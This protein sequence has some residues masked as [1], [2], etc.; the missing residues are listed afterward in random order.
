[1]SHP[2]TV[3]ADGGFSCR[4]DFAVKVAHM[5]SCAQAAYDDDSC[6]VTELLEEYLRGSKDEQ[7]CIEAFQKEW[8]EAFPGLGLDTISGSKRQ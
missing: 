1:M 5:M 2:K 8:P 3:L 4:P 6:G 7:E